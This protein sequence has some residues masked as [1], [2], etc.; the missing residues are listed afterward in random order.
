MVSDNY[1]SLQ[2]KVNC[3]IKKLIIGWS[4]INFLNFCDKF[5]QFYYE[6]KES[7]SILTWKIS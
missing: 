2:T 6:N 5:W 1:L 7:L 3:E 4:Q